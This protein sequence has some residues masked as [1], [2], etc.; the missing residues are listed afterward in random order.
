MVQALEYDFCRDAC[1]SI[2]ISLKN[3]ADY[4]TISV[5]QEGNGDNPDQNQW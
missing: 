1:Q 5:N 4:N 3:E 2:M